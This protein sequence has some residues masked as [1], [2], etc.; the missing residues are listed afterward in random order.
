MA[1]A[2]EPPLDIALERAILGTLFIDNAKIDLAA[3]IIEPEH[4]SEPVHGRIFEFMCVLRDEGTVT[5]LLVNSVMKTDPVLKELGGHSYFADMALSAPALLN[6]RDHA[7]QLRDLAVRRR[8][9]MIGN[10]IAQSASIDGDLSV[11]KQVASAVRA[12][13]EVAGELVRR[14]TQSGASVVASGVMVLVESALAGKPVPSVPTGLSKL[15]EAIGGLH[16]SDL[17]VIAGRSGMG[18]S[19]ML[20]GIAV[21]A[22]LAGHPTLVFSLEMKSRQW[23]ERTICDLDFDTAPKP[24]WYSHFRNG[25]LTKEEAARAAQV[26]YD[27]ITPQLPLEICDDDT[28]T[29][30]QIASR[31]RA[32]KAQHGGLGLIVCDYLQI[33][34]PIER[35]DR[36]REQEVTGFARGAKQLAKSLDWPVMFGAQLLT[37]GTEIS[38]GKERRPTLADIRESGSIEMEADLIL[39]PYRKAFFIQQRKPDF[40]FGSPEYEGWRNDIKQVAH[41]F[42]LFGLKA[43]HG[44]PFDLD[45]YCDMAASAIR[46]EE[47]YRPTESDRSADLLARAE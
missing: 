9:I 23:M 40:P 32:F 35:K 43:R 38:A 44:P 28:L 16:G 18:K 37:K 5:P 34:Q 42:E 19:A 31:S 47:P 17:I 11:T 6:I 46:D 22:A 4:F 20:G 29:I 24:M 33:V 12:V 7:R 1:D 25:R 45:L 36:S 2:I 10:D 3:A 39:C 15:D 14:D 26:V 21:R 41:K 13:D 8:L 27:R 30:H